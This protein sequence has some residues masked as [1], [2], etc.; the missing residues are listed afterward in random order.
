MNTKLLKVA[1][2]ASL[3]PLSLLADS[4]KQ[5]FP[6]E[7]ETVSLLRPAMRMFIAM[8][9]P[10]RKTVLSNPSLARDFGG[11]E[12]SF[13]AGVELGWR[14]SGDRAKCRYELLLSDSED[15]SNPVSIKAPHSRH[16]VQNLLLGKRYYWKVKANY[17]DGRPSLETKI[18]SFVVD[19]QP[20]RVMNVPNVDNVR[21]IG[22]WTGLEGRKIQQGLVYRSSGLNN[23]STDGGKTPGPNRFDDEGRKVLSEIMKVNLELDLRSKGE[24]AS[25]TVSPLGEQVKYINISTTC[26]GGMFTEI[27]RKNFAMLFKLFADKSNYPID[28]HCI[29]GADRTGSLSYL[30]L[31]VLGVKEEDVRLDYVFTS[32]FS[33]RGYINADIFQK[34]FN[35]YGTKDEPLYAKAE[36][37]LLSAG[38]TPQ[39]I[40]SFREIMLGTGLQNTPTLATHIAMA[41]ILAEFNAPLP[42]GCGIQS[43]SPLTE[44]FAQGG[45]TV[46]LSL[47]AWPPNFVSHSGARKDGAVAFH[48]SNNGAN[49]AFAK[50]TP[51]SDGN[52]MVADFIENCSFNAANGSSVWSAD[53]IRE[54][55]F[56]VLPGEQRVF[57][58]LPQGVSESFA[59]RKPLP[60][61]AEANIRV[62]DAKSANPPKIDGVL[63]D[64]A[65]RAATP[66]PLCAINGDALSNPPIAR[67]S[68]DKE[69]STLYISVQV[70]D[71]SPFGRKRDARD[72]DLWEEDSCEIFISN[73]G[74]PTYYQMI[75]NSFGDVYD[76]RLNDASWDV[77]DCIIATKQGDNSWTMELALPLAQFNFTAPIEINICGSDCPEKHLFNLTPTSGSFHSRQCL[78][79]VRLK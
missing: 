41:K 10:A 69:H 46:K 22:G 42:K 53:A 38:I 21:D 54:A 77:K 73:L 44:E 39:E 32:F 74:Q 62:F 63:D 33:L 29:A 55:I 30:L 31:A 23:N 60:P 11:V 2:A 56:T 66:L 8:D 64:D 24:T 47:P 26:Y 28:F 13:P 35:E 4:L 57:L 70:P 1:L 20:P 61:L 7:G 17:T 15:F 3:L 43:Y 75:I 14:F 5:E 51:P 27:G 40:I 72:G 12:R 9:E 18:Q 58:L 50:I 78:S 52:Y 45:K 67:I 6:A 76:S 36:R 48:L 59:T 49:P 79:P 25:M 16:R 34:G 68:T 19:P 71:S 37:Y 65:W